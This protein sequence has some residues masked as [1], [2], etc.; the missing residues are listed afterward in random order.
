M[1]PKYKS[2]TIKSK[3]TKNNWLLKQ[4]NLRKHMPRLMLFSRSNL[5]TMLGAYSVVFFKPT[6]GS[7]GSNIIRVTKLAHGY[8]TQFNTTKTDYSTIDQ[9][10]PALKRFSKNKPYLLQEGVVLAKSNGKPFDIRV[11][12]QKTEAGYWK[13][14]GMFTK[15]GNPRKVATNFNQGGKIGY[16]CS[17]LSG[18]GF[19]P[20]FIERMEAK[21]KQVGVTVGKR[22]DRQYKGFKELG[23]DVALDPAGKPWILEVNTR[24]QI[25]PLKTLKDTALHRRIAK[26]AKRY[27]RVEK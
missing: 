24:P 16:F 4:A 10:Y 15:I 19:H 8:R 1:V 23:L 25:Y 12:V 18:A 26:Y 3:W 5:K 9:L 11:M 7:G 13:T 21:L 2:S 27:G 20:D 22:F 6:N 17:T 14:T